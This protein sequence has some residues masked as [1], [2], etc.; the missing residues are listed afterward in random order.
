[1]FDLALPSQLSGV[2]TIVV[3]LTLGAL[4]ACSAITIT[5]PPSTH[6]L[7]AKLPVYLASENGSPPAVRSVVGSI[8]GLSCRRLRDWTIDDAAQR[9]DAIDQL[10]LRALNAGANGVIDVRYVRIQADHKNLCYRGLA[11][12]GTA[13]RLASASTQ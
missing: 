5:A 11:A 13:V 3:A 1:M 9:A 10:R 12:E 6:T 8:Q 2:S 4:S 7:A